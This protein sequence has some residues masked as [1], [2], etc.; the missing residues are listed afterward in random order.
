MPAITPHLA[1]A[2]ENMA[3]SLAITI[4]AAAAIP[5]PPPKHPP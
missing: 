1:S 4:S 3:S 2:I 5:V